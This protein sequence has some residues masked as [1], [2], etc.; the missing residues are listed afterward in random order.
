MSN[1]KLK[2]NVTELRQIEKE[3][4]QRLQND[5]KEFHQEITKNNEELIKVHKAIS[6]KR[7]LYLIGLNV[8]LLIITGFTIYVAVKNTIKKSEYEILVNEKDE[9]RNQLE[10]VKQFFNEN[11][12]TAKSFNE[13]SKRNKTLKY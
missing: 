2:V 1:I 12:K 8:F 13:W 6:S 4:R 3:Q 11:T 9:L 7:L 10:N 5:F